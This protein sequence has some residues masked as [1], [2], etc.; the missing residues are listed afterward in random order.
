ML[1]IAAVVKI[2]F[3][4]IERQTINKEKKKIF[5]KK[6]VKKN[7]NKEIRYQILNFFPIYVQKY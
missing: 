7:L 2:M 1:S 3:L 5:L 6:E 4:R